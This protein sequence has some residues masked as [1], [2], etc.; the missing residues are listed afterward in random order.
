[1]TG[2]RERHTIKSIRELLQVQTPKSR[3]V[4]EIVG[5][6]SRRVGYKSRREKPGRVGDRGLASDGLRCVYCKSNGLYLFA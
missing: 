6:L 2:T 3:C 1:M 5:H 4:I